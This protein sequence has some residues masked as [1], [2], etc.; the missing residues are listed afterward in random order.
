M[1]KVFVLIFALGFV[2]LLYAQKSKKALQEQL[3]G[4]WTLVSVDNI[5]PDSSRVYPYGKNPQGMLIFDPKGNYAIQILKTIRSKIVSGDKNNCT[6]EENAM[7]VQG[8]NSHFGKYSA[9]EVNKTITFNISHASFPNWEG[10]V[11]K[12]SYTYNGNEIKYV[13]THTTQGGQ[14]VIAEVSWKRLQ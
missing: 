2:S 6:P 1:K 4:T 13:V 11:Q 8:S 9:D 14:A 7:I 10:T 5:Y 3:I 12:R